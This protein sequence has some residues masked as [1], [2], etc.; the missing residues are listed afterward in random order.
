VA[1]GAVPSADPAGITGRALS[2]G[3]AVAA[4]AISFGAVSV[5][6]G[7]GVWQTQALSILMFTG[8]S[9]FAFV[10]VV[11]AAVGWWPQ[12]RPRSC[13]ASATASTGCTWRAS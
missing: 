11:A 9:Q 4:Y 5:A 12:W 6:T 3:I 10:G 1:A 13:W 8:A 7:L 2:I